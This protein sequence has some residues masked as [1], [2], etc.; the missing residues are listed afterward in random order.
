MSPRPRMNFGDRPPG[1]HRMAFDVPV[2]LAKEVAEARDG[3][4]GA[5]S[6]LVGTAAMALFVGLPPEAREALYRWVHSH[7]L[8]PDRLD[9]S[10]AV[11]RLVPL[12]LTLGTLSPPT[13]PS[14][15]KVS[16]PLEPGEFEVRYPARQRDG[17]V[18]QQVVTYRAQQLGT[19]TTEQGSGKR[20]A[21]GA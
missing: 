12:L 8:D 14:G 20:A 21:G 3:L 15:G 11:S 1:W 10:E 18:E 5:S 13:G 9:T 19:K 16:K 4:P 17:Y 2:K 6:K 7:E